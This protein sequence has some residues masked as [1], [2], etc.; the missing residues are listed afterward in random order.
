MFII[1]GWKIVFHPIDFSNRFPP[2][3]YGWK[4]KKM[5]TVFVFKAELQKI[6]DNIIMRI[7]TQRVCLLKNHIM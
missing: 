5:S 4:G 6:L 7:I 1:F 3:K 2:L